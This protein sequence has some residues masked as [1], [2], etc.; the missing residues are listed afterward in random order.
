VKKSQVVLRNAFGVRTSGG[1]YTHCAFA[2][3]QNWENRTT[4]DQCLSE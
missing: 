1:R 2:C 3:V 4:I